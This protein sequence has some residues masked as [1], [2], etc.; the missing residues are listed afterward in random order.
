MIKKNSLELQYQNTFIKMYPELKN[1]GIPVKPVT[2]VVTQDCNLRCTYCYQHNK[3][4]DK[5]FT[6]ETAVKFIDMLFKLDAENNGYIN[7][8]N[9]YAIV[10]EFIGGE[11]LLEIDLIDFT[12]EYFKYKCIMLR[13]RWGVHHMINITTNGVLYENE[14]V[15][16]FLKKN[17]G[18]V[19]ISITIDGNKELHDSCRLFPDGTGSYDIVEKAFK[20]YLETSHIKSTKLTLSPDNI[21]YLSD[22][23]IHLFNIGL[24]TIFSNCIFEKGW[25]V[26]HARVLY[27]QMK[28]LADYI[29]NNNLYENYSCSLFDASIGHV[30]DE[31][32]NQ[33]WCGGTGKMLA[34]DSDGI[35][36][37]CLRYLPFSLKEGCKPVT[38]GLIENGIGYSSE[39]IETISMLN[40]V[41]R[42][43]QSTDEC[44][45]CPIASGCAWCSAYNYEETGSVDKRV[46][47]IC[48]M[49]KARVLANSYYWNMLHEKFN[50]DIKF[51]LKIPK[52]WA[53]EIITETE[54]DLLSKLS[55]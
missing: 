10:L 48:I 1:D 39:D 25:N 34:V 31:N 6:K 3:N 44:F 27:E 37:P 5:K 29:I 32:D 4:R 16:T 30:L 35:I 54:Y 24:C 2:I 41:T 9:S 28:I 55:S 38:I 43:S 7:S 19:S 26:E 14:D 23:C 22:A 52:E 12:V 11:P 15:Q 33:N 13:H 45:Y 51:P 53:V 47:Y 21:M 17:E 49:H 8:K 50:E 20:S 40:K 36:Y 46:T 18:R 42:R